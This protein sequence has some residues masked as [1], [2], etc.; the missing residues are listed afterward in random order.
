VVLKNTLISNKRLERYYNGQRNKLFFLVFRK[1]QFIPQNLQQ[2]TDFSRVYLMSSVH[3]FVRRPVL[4]NSAFSLTSKVNVV[5]LKMQTD[6][7]R[8]S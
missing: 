2:L 1:Y 6:S 8:L 3:L 5:L 7:F 4:D